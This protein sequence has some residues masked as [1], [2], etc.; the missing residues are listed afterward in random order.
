MGN[1]YK[2]ITVRGP[3]QAEIAAA[4][5]KHGRRCYLTPTRDAVTVVFDHRSDEEGDPRELGDL[6]LTLSSDLACPAL[7]AAVFDDDVLLLAL[8]DAGQQLGEYNSAGASTLSA[9]ALVRAFRAPRRAAIVWLLLESPRLPLFMFESF[10]HRLLLRA[11]GQPPWAFATG[12]RY[13]EKGE[14][15]EDLG[16]AELR[17]VDGSHPGA[18]G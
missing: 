7:A 9:A 11:L 3:Q 1:W 16:T 8:Y 6:A 14:P 18:G 10:R 4:L 17:H 12:Y 15:P 13:I 2:N 5:A